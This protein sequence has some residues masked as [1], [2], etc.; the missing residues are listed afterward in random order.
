M[1]WYPNAL[2]RVVL[3]PLLYPLD[4]GN[5]P[6]FWWIAVTRSCDQVT[7]K[8]SPHSRKLLSLQHSNVY[9]HTYNIQYIYILYYQI[10]SALGTT[11]L[12]N[13]QYIFRQRLKQPR[14]VL[15]ML[16]HIPTFL[17]SPSYL[18]NLVMYPYRYQPMYGLSMTSSR[19]LGGD[20]VPGDWYSAFGNIWMSCTS[21]WVMT[22]HE[23]LE[24]QFW[25]LVVS[26]D[27]RWYSINP[28]HF[29]IHIHDM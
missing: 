4:E 14:G 22:Q 21:D 11:M 23:H 18:V 25:A 12:P 24:S 29:Q 17:V 16:I 10:F 5:P 8:F 1:H 19:G 6:V 27:L 7:K 9:P 26:N 20:A 15:G 13:A 28:Q 2:S 3:L